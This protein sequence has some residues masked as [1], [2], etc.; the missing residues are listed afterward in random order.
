MN[1]CVVRFSFSCKLGGEMNKAGRHHEFRPRSSMKSRGVHH[2]RPKFASLPRNHSHH[3]G[4]IE[5]LMMPMG[6]VTV[7][8]GIFPQLRKMSL[9]G[10][11]AALPWRM[12]QASRQP[13]SDRI[14]MPV[15]HNP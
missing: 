5:S 1:F 10:A 3:D 8:A 4:I 13:Q 7:V 2:E 11:T 9:H 15:F 6:V 12:A 14:V